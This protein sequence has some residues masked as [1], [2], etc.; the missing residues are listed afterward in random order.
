MEDFVKL[1]IDPKVDYAFKRVFGR[2]TNR[3]ILLHL[4]NAVL[5]PP[6][7]DEVWIS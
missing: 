5:R 1:G 2:V 4:I 6:G 3:D 7:I